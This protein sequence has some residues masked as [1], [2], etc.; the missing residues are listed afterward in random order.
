MIDTLPEIRFFSN[1]QACRLRSGHVIRNL[2]TR[3]Y[4]VTTM[5]WLLL[6]L[7]GV[8]ALNEVITHPATIIIVV[9]VALF[10]AAIP[11]LFEY[12]ALKSMP[13]R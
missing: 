2:P 9:G 11:Y 5:A 3:L 12:L 8:S 1:R 7:A 6:P 10:S 13:T 4:F